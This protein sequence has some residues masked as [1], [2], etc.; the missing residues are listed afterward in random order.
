MLLRVCSNWNLCDA[1]HGTK[2]PEK[3]SGIEQKKSATVKTLPDGQWTGE[4]LENIGIGCPNHTRIIL[5]L[6]AWF[7]SLD[8]ILV[9]TKLRMQSAG[10]DDHS[11]T[12]GSKIIHQKK[13]CPK[14][15]IRGGSNLWSKIC[16]T[17][18][19]I[20]LLTKLTWWVSSDCWI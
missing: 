7:Y 13:P 8:L 2:V 20:A 16:F 11:L 6:F 5:G 15:E 9:P 18:C 12:R 10:I 14:T 1:S 4:L 19:H 17:L 3:S